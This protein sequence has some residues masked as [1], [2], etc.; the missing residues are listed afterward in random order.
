MAG[1][2]QP[3]KNN[4]ESNSSLPTVVFIDYES[5]FWGMFNHFGETPDLDTFI[6]DIKKRGKL[7]NIKVF[8]D[9]SKTEYAGELKKI[10]TITNDIIDCRNMNRES[11]KDYLDFIM[12]DSIYQTI[13]NQPG[14]M[15]YILV[16]GDGHFSSVATFLRT[17]KDK[18]V[19]IYGVKG[20][21]STQL[22]DCSSWAV[23]IINQSLSKNHLVPKIIDTLL[24][25]YNNKMEMTFRWTV[26]QASKYHGEEE[27][28]I[29]AVLSKLISDGY[30]LQKESSAGN[31][32]M[33]QPRWNLIKRSLAPDIVIE[34]EHD[35]ND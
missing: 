35:N 15:Q 23:E 28:K 5:L 18:T 6:T 13:N 3:V 7:E 8:A 25:I 11:K 17:V 27:T 34:T 9:L 31:Y 14:L 22:I 10:R 12:L 29:A 26:R 19:G 32:K 30:I 16:T 2:Y 24:W 20:S 33:M 4:P 21:I 1:I